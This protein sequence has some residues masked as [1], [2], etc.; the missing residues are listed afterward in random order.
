M[1]ATR[2]E[3]P[4]NQNI[5]INSSLISFLFL[6]FK[7]ILA[8]QLWCV[9][10]ERLLHLRMGLTVDNSRGRISRLALSVFYN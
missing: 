4:I 10:T 1:L 9:Q 6:F 8:V 3:E 5:G 2:T 7:I